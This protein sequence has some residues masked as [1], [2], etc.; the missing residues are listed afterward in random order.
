MGPMMRAQLWV[1]LPFYW[2][3]RGGPREVDAKKVMLLAGRSKFASGGLHRGIK[4]IAAAMGLPDPIVARKH[5]GGVAYHLH[6]DFE[7]SWEEAERREGKKLDW[8]E[9]PVPAARL[10]GQGQP[11]AGKDKP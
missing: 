4:N 5:G 3:H 7:K 6:P 8:T 1:V 11:P 2:R 10:Q 9:V